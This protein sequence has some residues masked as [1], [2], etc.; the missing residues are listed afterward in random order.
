[1]VGELDRVKIEGRATM[2]RSAHNPKKVSCLAF[3]STKLDPG[4]YKR[5]AI[6]DGGGEFE[7]DDGSGVV[8]IVRAEHFLIV[9]GVEVDGQT[10]VPAGARVEV[11]GDARWDVASSDRGA[12]HARQAA[13]VVRVEGSIDRPLLL[14]VIADQSDARSPSGVRVDPSAATETTPDEREAAM[15]SA[16]ARDRRSR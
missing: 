11:V 6:V 10:I 13:R 14:R 9:G 8:A 4:E 7:I 1:M 12:S 15:V 3:E 16:E 2:L 5:G